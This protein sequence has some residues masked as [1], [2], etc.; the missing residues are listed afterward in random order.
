MIS[1]LSC[2]KAS[3][4]LLKGQTLF[5]VSKMYV[6]YNMDVS[7]LET[8]REPGKLDLLDVQIYNVIVSENCVV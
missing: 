2:K 6:T 8:G 7:L 5:L 3:F 4:S 1:I